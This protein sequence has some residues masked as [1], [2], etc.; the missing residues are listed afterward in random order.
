MNHRV[1]ESNRWRK[2]SFV[3]WND[4][5]ASRIWLIDTVAVYSPAAEFE[6]IS[7]AAG[8]DA[9]GGQSC[10]A[11]NSGWYVTYLNVILI[12]EY[13]DRDYLR[14]W[15]GAYCFSR[16]FGNL[17]GYSFLAPIRESAVDIAKRLSAIRH[18]AARYFINVHGR[19]FLSSAF[20][21]VTWILISRA[22]QMSY[23]RMK[24]HY[25]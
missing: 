19:G 4:P 10:R 22:Y 24:I 23:S 11:Y 25:L 14:Y 7:A 21:I 15:P 12:H 2:F 16:C 5:I 8:W 13:A 17:P 9:G 20:V 3:N 18:F 6:T 1:F